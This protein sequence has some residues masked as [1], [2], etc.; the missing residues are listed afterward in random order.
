MKTASATLFLICFVIASLFAEIA[1]GQVIYDL[2]SALRTAKNSNLS[3]KTEHFNIEEA[4]TDVTTAGLRPNPSLNNQTLQLTDHTYYPGNTEWHNARNRQ[5]WWQLTRTFQLPNQRGYKIQVAEQTLEVEALDY[6]EKERNVLF[7]AATKWQEAMNAQ[8]S[9]ATLQ[10]A[11]AI[12]DTLVAINRLR[13][14]DKVISETDLIRAELV[15]DQYEVQLKKVRSESVRK[16]MQLKLTMGLRDSIQIN[17]NDSIPFRSVPVLDSLLNYSF[18]NRADIRKARAALNLY[19]SNR[20]L[21]RVLTLPAPL[22]GAIWNPQNTIP[23]VGFYGTIEIPAFN[24]NQGEIQ[25]SDIR[26]QQGFQNLIVVHSM[27]EQQVKSSYNSFIVNHESLKTFESTLRN[28]DVVLESVRYS[29]IKGG[30]T[31]LD[32]LDAQR[33]RMEIQRQYGAIVKQYRQNYIE[34]L[35]YSGL[36][37]QLAK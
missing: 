14:K 17:M 26:Q 25:K 3:L 6:L 21:Q 33:S 27:I 34:L 9:V 11:K 5:V 36:I 20:K 31:L 30:T 29:Y 19:E 8:K 12:M 10:K 22:L 24:R 16:L 18:N 15:A 37:N 4:V 13:F 1:D 23:Y 35:F 7:E 2:Q 28:A 32:F